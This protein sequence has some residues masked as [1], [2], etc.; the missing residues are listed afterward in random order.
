MPDDV[1]M[2]IDSA[3]AA[4]P[5]SNEARAPQIS[6]PSTRGPGG[7]CPAGSRARR[8]VGRAVTLV[9]SSGP[10]ADH[11]REQR[12][13]DDDDQQAEADHAGRCATNSRHTCGAAARR[14]AATA[15]S[16][17]GSRVDA[18]VTRL[19]SGVEH[20]VEQVGDEVHH[21][22]DRREHDEGALQQR[23]VGRAERLVGE[24]AE[25]GPGEH[26]LDRD[27]AGDQPP[28][29]RKTSVTV[30]S[31]ALGTACRGAPGRRAGPWR[32]PS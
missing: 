24:L 21:D 25:A 5:T 9:T 29:C 22:D 2:T 16:R 19:H 20:A 28:R 13:Q 3:V 17:G 23:Q 1:P 26:R 11:R 6:S 18:H 27:R 32:A 8:V 30:G 12:E 7:R 14:R 4:N 10:S 31:S 15:A